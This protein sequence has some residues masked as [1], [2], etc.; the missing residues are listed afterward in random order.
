[1]KI[2]SYHPGRLIWLI[3][4]ISV[5]RSMVGFVVYGHI[6]DPLWKNRPLALKYDFSVGGSILNSTF[7]FGFFSFDILKVWSFAYPVIKFQRDTRLFS[8]CTD[9]EKEWRSFLAS[10]V[11]GLTALSI[12]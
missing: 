2:V 4:Q 10:Y 1:M 9:R 8:A 5:Q 12:D 11:N 3:S 6:C 7:I